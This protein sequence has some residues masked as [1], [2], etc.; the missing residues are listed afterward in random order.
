M[1]K[2]PRGAVIAGRSWS[3]GVTDNPTQVKSVPHILTAAI[4]WA[5][6][7]SEYWHVKGET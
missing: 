6:V 5:T 2:T 7:K 4:T 1:W 3:P